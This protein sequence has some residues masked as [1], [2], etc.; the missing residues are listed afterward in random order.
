MRII[1]QT[2]ENTHQEK[3]DQLTI[4]TLIYKSK[5]TTEELHYLHQDD[6]YFKSQR[7]LNQETT[8]STVTRLFA[9]EIW[10]KNSQ[11]NLPQ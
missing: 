2:T 3:M 6:L 11:Q 1:F 7:C 4:I 10:G 9:R 8:Q 5:H